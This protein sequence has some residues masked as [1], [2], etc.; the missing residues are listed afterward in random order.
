MRYVRC[1][2]VVVTLVGCGAEI[3]QAVT[4]K[5]TDHAGALTSSG[6][7]KLFDLKV[8][9]ADEQ[10]TLDALVLTFKQAGQTPMALN[11]ELSDDANGDG[12]VGAGDTLTGIEPGL[13]ILGTPQA[14]TQY[15]V[16]LM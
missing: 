12:K 16:E 13:N 15:E 6:S 3:D 14:G 5:L 8:T 10:Y 2:A 9:E 4:A 11:Y 1:V 7:D